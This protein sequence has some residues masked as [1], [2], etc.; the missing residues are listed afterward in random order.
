MSSSSRNC[1]Y[2]FDVF[3]YNVENTHLKKTEKILA[4]LSRVSKQKY[5]KEHLGHFSVRLS[6]PDK[7]WTLHLVCK[8]CLEHLHQ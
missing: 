6:C 8:T 2:H 1:V 7:T 4:I 5:K 3:C